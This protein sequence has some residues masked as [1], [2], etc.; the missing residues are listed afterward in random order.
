MGLTQVILKGSVQKKIREN[1][2]LTPFTYLYT[3]SKFF[4][5]LGKSK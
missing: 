1:K 2:S 5:S 4:E 3:Y